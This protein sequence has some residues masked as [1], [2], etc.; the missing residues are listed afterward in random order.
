MQGCRCT[1]GDCRRCTCA[2]RGT[3]CGVDCRCKE[4]VC[5]NRPHEEVE[6]F[7]IGPEQ[8]AEQNMAAGQQA[9]VDALQ[10]MVQGM[11]NQQE[12]QQARHAELLAQLHNQ[13]GL[14]SSALATIPVFSGAPSESLADWEAAIERV[15]VAEGWDAVRRR[16]AA[17]SKLSGAALSWQN[18]TGHALEEW[19]GW[20]E[21]L[22]VLFRPRL[23]LTEWCLLVEGRRQA[24]GE[25]SALYAMEKMKIIRLCPNVLNEA[26]SVSYLIRGLNRQEHV[27]AM[28]GNPPATV[29]DFVE[30][31]RGLEQ[32][33]G[34]STT[35]ATLA[36]HLG[37]VSTTSASK[38]QLPDAQEVA[39]PKAVADQLAGLT[40][41]LRRLESM[42]RTSAGRFGPAGPGPAM[43]PSAVATGPPPAAPVGDP[44][45]GYVPRADGPAPRPR[46]PLSEVQC[47]EC[48]RYGHF[49]R[50]CPD[51]RTAAAY[52]YSGNDL[53][54][55]PGQGWPE[56]P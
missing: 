13:N 1:V 12:G 18:Q 15:T 2:R 38:P 22:R 49:A 50:E 14:R 45:A 6:E 21:G 41:A 8:M 19:A 35:L 9:L 30:R 11:N 33:G 48:S 53:A 29:V 25:S 32:M 54:S 27:A 37:T 23:S 10:A 7:F 42:M 4:E 44:R 24:P 20:I 31:A 28:M 47:Y 56:S 17:I 16:R 36:P 5:V 26:D 40:V 34:V 55:L 39:I 3:N 52:Y 43:G 51:R 46:R